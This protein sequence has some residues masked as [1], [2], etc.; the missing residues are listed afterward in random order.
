MARTRTFVTLAMLAIA[1]ASSAGCQER[2]PKVPGETDVLV[3]EVS[4]EPAEPGAP[5]ELQ[6]KDLYDKLG[7]RPGSR[8]GSLILTDRTWSPFR[9]AE[10]RRRITAYWEGFGYLDVEVAAPRV[11]TTGDGKKR[12]SW[13]VRENRRY[14]V[15]EVR[16]QHAPPDQEAALR[17]LVPMKVGT[18]EIDFERYRNGRI[19]MQEYLRIHGYGHANV[20]SRTWVDRRK[21]QLTWVYFTDAGPRTTIGKIVVD[22]NRRVSAES[23]IE[24]AGIHG[25]EPYTEDLRERIVRDLLDTGSF[26]SVF[27]RVDT[28]TK[29]IPPGTLPDSGGE[30][31]DE[32][33]DA[34]GNLVPRKLSEDVLVT[35]H[36]V[37]GRTRT[38]RLGARFEIDP[39]RAD[40]SLGA[41][42]WFRD[43]FGSM[44][45]L[46]LEGRLGYGL[47]LDGIDRN[48]GQDGLYGEALLR[49]VH[50]GAL[51]RT[52]DLRLS[53]R[54]RHE[55]FPDSA[56]REMSVGPGARW[57][58]D[59]G[60]F[61]DVDLL[62][63][64]SQSLGFGPFS[65]ADRAALSLPDDDEAGGPQLDAAITW[66]ARNDGIEPMKGH[67]LRLATRISP[68]VPIATNRWVDLSP[69]ARLY[70]P[71]SDA[72]SVGLRG[73]AG[74]VMG[75]DEHGIPLGARLFG[76][77]AYG[78]RGLGR[79]RLAPE[80]VDCY[81]P[82]G[83]EPTICKSEV[84][85]GASLA[86]TSAE[87]RF[88]KPRSQVGAV[89]FFDL[90]GVSG[91]LNPFDVGPSLAAGLGGRLR[92]WYLPLAI[93]VGWRFVDGGE[94]VAWDDDPIGV[95]FRL[96]EAF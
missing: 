87:L 35:I 96:G 76:G 70:L 58:L 3:A 59:K 15:G 41:K 30:L 5:L 24:R 83:A 74:F 64:Y 7:M 47:W 14:A 56:L 65:P 53:A 39:S 71:L 46:V 50:A 42:A 4:I 20:Y 63:M 31:R 26:Q 60:L 1:P 90:A 21:K 85:G 51:G 73:S 72:L 91:N 54:V 86:E 22:G 34:Q 19:D 32:Q 80:V 36:V 37:E 61:V 82:V 29:F 40:T 77:G 95:F 69:D 66:D 18:T 16:V 28:D 88:L 81:G 27:V 93:D 6:H 45:H 23:I 67:L 11:E 43:L 92:L 62:G 2:P 10:D 17:G 52:G 25:G 38:L 48:D 55:P 8:P 79:K 68:G 78:F 44:D 89:A 9:E 84:V 57:N 75:D 33:I 94:A 12:I 13:W 49:T